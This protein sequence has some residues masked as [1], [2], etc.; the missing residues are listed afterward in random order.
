MLDLSFP[1]IFITLHFWFVK[2]KLIHIFILQYTNACH[3]SLLA[4]LFGE[5]LL[6]E[7]KPMSCC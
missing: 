2:S 7:Y 4:T 3:N 1:L 5:S 6:D